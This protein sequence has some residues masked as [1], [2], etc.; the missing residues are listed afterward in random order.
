M[1]CGKCKKTTCVKC[2]PLFKYFKPKKKIKKIEGFCCLICLKN[3]KNKLNKNLICCG[4]PFEDYYKFLKYGNYLYY[5]NKKLTKKIEGDFIRSKNCKINNHKNCENCIKLKSK[6]Y[7]LTNKIKKYQNFKFDDDEKKNFYKLFKNLKKFERPNNNKIENNDINSFKNE[8]INILKLKNDL[9]SKKLEHMT[10]NKIFN[11][12]GLNNEQ[13]YLIKSLIENMNNNKLSKFFQE[14]LFS[15]FENMKNKISN[16]NNYSIEIKNFWKIVKYLGGKKIIELFRGNSEKLNIDHKIFGTNIN[17]NFI[18]PSNST[19]K[20]DK[21]PIKYGI[22]FSENEKNKIIEKINEF[23]KK[24]EITEP[25]FFLAFDEVDIREGI[26]N[27]NNLVYGNGEPYN[28]DDL[29]K[30]FDKENLNSQIIQF[31]FIFPF[32]NFRLPIAAFLLPPKNPLTVVVENIEKIIEFLNEYKFSG[33]IS[34]GSKLSTKI[35]KELKK[36]H[37]DIL[38]FFDIGHLL[39]H[40][41]NNLLKN[42][43][44]DNGYVFNMSNLINLIYEK[45]LK[46][47]SNTI[48]PV[49]KQELSPVL[50]LI[51]TEVLVCAESSSSLNTKFGLSNYLKN[52]KKFKTIFEYK[53]EPNEKY[54]EN[55]FFFFKKSIEELLNYFKNLSGVTDDTINYVITTLNSILTF[56]EKKK[57]FT[58]NMGSFTSNDVEI[59]FS[60]MRNKINYFNAFEYFLLFNENFKIFKILTSKDKLFTFS[61][62]LISKNYSINNFNEN[63]IFENIKFEKTKKQPLKKLNNEQLNILNEYKPIK[64]EIKIR[65]KVSKKNIKL[66]IPCP[67]ISVGECSHYQYYKIYQ[68]LENHL[69]KEHHLNENISSEICKL[70]IETSSKFFQKLNDDS[71][72]TIMLPNEEIKNVYNILIKKINEESN[73]NNEIHEH[74]GLQISNKENKNCETNLIN[75]DNNFQI[76]NKIV[77]TTKQSINNNINNNNDIQTFNNNNENILKIIENSDNINNETFNNNIENNLQIIE[78]YDNINM[79]L[80]L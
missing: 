16:T 73:Y 67:Y 57:K 5:N 20:R 61:P 41:R 3:E 69:I 74:N 65:D 71:F 66:M 13:K 39:K 76:C 38:H 34:D 44:N 7:Y 42:L 15:Q 72:K 48:F 36:K 23:N 51:S 58:F 30:N 22:V 77:E 18:V 75:N 56:L 33:I 54:F 31:F 19:L 8:N 37:T 60:I 52:M 47:S 70:L 43:I 17:S 21:E 62:K 4:F 53:N 10:E 2:P 11:I 40:L 46:I 6:L 35:Y 78:N 29:V 25:D 14:F 59:F 27:H 63:I 26:V 28:I 24:N 12:E 9:L 68:R 45:K 1:I 79:K 55:N 64:K 50:K 32:M 49:D 80:I